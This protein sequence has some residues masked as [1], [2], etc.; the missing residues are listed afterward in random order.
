MHTWKGWKEVCVAEHGLWTVIFEPY[1]VPRRFPALSYR[2]EEY[3]TVDPLSSNG[4]AA[5]A[6]SQDTLKPGRLQRGT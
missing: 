4:K 5:E 6:G 1:T 3:R 2:V